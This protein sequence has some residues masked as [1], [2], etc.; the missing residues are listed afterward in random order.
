MMVMECRT[1]MVIK[2]MGISR[3]MIHAQP[4]EEEKLKERSRDAKRVK[5]SDSDF[6]HSWSD[7]HECSRSEDEHVDHLRI[8]LQVLKDQQL[9]P[10]FSKC[11]FWLRSVALLGYIVSGKGIKVDPKKTDVVKS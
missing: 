9:F 4:I 3:L 1:T 11:E 10:K 8:V 6:S 2:K 5:T 7:G